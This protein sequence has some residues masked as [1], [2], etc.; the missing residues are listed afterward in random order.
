MVCKR[1]WLYVVV[2]VN[3]NTVFFVVVG[4]M[5]NCVANF[6]KRREAIQVDSE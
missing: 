4:S 3:N 6:A 2:V 5:C 1:E